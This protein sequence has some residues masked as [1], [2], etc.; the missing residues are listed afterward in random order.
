MKNKKTVLSVASVIIVFSAV[1][2]IKLVSP[3][4]QSQFKD[5]KNNISHSAQSSENSAFDNSQK[6]E[7]SV[8]NTTIKPETVQNSDYMSEPTKGIDTKATGYQDNTATTTTPSAV[9]K[10]IQTTAPRTTAE[11]N[12]EKRSELNARYGL[13]IRYGK[14]IN[15]LYG[16]YAP[17]G[18]PLELLVNDNEISKNLKKL[19]DCLSQYPDG[20]F[21]ETSRNGMTLSI[22]LVKGSHDKFAGLVDYQFTS[23]PIMT[24]TDAFMFSRVFHHEMMHFLDLYMQV[25]QYPDNPY[26]NWSQYNPSG[27]TYGY[28]DNGENVFFPHGDENAYF[29]T[30]YSKTNEREDRAELFSEMMNGVYQKSCL[31]S[32]KHIRAKADAI[33]SALERSFDCITPS[34]KPEWTKNLK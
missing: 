5:K 11:L 32:G 2:L 14:E 24:I 16:E 10:P 12:N 4:A 29:F 3:E 6:S 8:S 25:R 31:K 34:S 19:E 13:D 30:D 22:F 26:G 21:N 27:Y 15:D 1:L 7:T 17:Y 28:T 9:T 23:N 20:M 18:E 33:A